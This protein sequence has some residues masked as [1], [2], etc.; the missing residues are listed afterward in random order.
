MFNR[1]L[2]IP[3]PTK[4]AN[5]RYQNFN[6]SSWS[7]RP[8]N[9]PSNSRPA[10][11]SRRYCCTSPSTRNTFL[12]RLPVSDSIIIMWVVPFK[13][14]FLA[15]HPRTSTFKPAR[16]TCFTTVSA[17][18][19]SCRHGPDHDLNKDSPRFQIMKNHTI[20]LNL[21]L[22]LFL[23]NSQ[24]SIFLFFLFFLWGAARKL[25]TSWGN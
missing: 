2:M 18:A 9:Y 7:T 3:T 12:I 20:S 19:I 11:W 15:N 1:K 4:H 13:S 16:K 17:L 24:S 5:C 8:A 10:N 6:L 23:K 25:R 21:S 14:S 22:L